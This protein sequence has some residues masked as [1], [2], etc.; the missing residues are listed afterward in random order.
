MKV[1]NLSEISHSM[2]C[3]LLHYDP[4]AGVLIQGRHLWLEREI[5][6]WIQHQWSSAS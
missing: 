6:D 1:N 5:D 4:A 3:E 2:I